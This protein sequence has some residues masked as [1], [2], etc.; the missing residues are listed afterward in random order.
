MWAGEFAQAAVSGAA[1][2]WSATMPILRQQVTGQVPRR[3][4]ES[5]GWRVESIAGPASRTLEWLDD[6]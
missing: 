5:V 3:T 1:P 4:F 2:A 6:Q